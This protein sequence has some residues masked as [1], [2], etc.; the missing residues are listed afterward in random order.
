[1]VRMFRLDAGQSRSGQGLDVVRTDGSAPTSGVRVGKNADSAGSRHHPD[2]FRG[3]EL[4]PR[5]SI[6]TTRSDPIGRER[7]VDIPYD[8]GLDQRRGDVRPADRASA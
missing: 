5:Y 4:V 6:T 7:L 2:S 8:S 3:V 1:M